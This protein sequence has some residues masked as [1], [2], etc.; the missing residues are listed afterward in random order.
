VQ[1]QHKQ[2]QVV[3]SLIGAQHTA[4]QL[5]RNSAF[6]FG[7]RV[8][9]SQQ[10]HTLIE[11]SAAASAASSKRVMDEVQRSAHSVASPSTYKRT[12]A[13]ELL[14]GSTPKQAFT[15]IASSAV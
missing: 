12:P 14:N 15:S 1:Q 10:S 4:K 7:A 2:Y 11:M 5:E 6:C 9:K 8:L 3:F 13:S